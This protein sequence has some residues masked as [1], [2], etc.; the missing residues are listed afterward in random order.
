MLQRTEHALDALEEAICTAAGDLTTACRS[1]SINPREVHQWAMS[2]PEVQGR[3]KTAQ[4]IGWAS[5]ES[6]AYRRAVLGVQEDV[7]YKGDVCGQRTVYSDG[8]LSKLL[9]A[10]VPGFK[11]DNSDGK[12]VTVNVNLMPRASTYEEWLGHKEEAAKLL[13]DQS[14]EGVSDAARAAYALMRPPVEVQDAEYEE[15]SVLRDVL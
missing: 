14:G 2:D 1:L 7:Y 9:D 5:L 15:V 6:E 8:L 13:T 3:I 11:T 10:R 4:M 12:G